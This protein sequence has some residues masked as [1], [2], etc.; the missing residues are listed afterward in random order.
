MMTGRF[1]LAILGTLLEEA[2]LAAVVLWGLPLLGIHLPLAGLIALMAALLGCLR[3]ASAPL[4]KNP[5]PS[6]LKE[7]GIKG[8]R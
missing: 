8:V 1:I 3:G 4:Y 7:R 2:A 5:F 6:P